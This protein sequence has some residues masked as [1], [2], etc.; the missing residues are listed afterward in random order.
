MGQILD[1][2][3]AGVRVAVIRLRSLG[4]CVLTTPALELL[5]TARPD[6]TIGVVVE[7][8]FAP[9]FEG[10]PH[11]D[12]ILA[13]ATRVVS[14]FSPRL[15]INLHGGTRSMG[16]TF[17]SGAPVRAGFAHHRYSFVYNV[18]IPTAEK[19]LGVQR[20]VHT[21]EHLG[22]AM[23]HLGVPAREIPR[24]RLYAEP[25]QDGNC[26]VLHAM[27]S[28][29]QKTW[30][31]E[32]FLAVAR[33]IEREWNIEPVFIGGRGEDLGAFHG[34]RTLVG[35]PLQRIK[36]LLSGAALFVGND[37]GPAHMAAAF[38]VPSVVI[39]GA[40]DPEIWG[41]WRTASQVLGGD[42]AIASIAVDTVVAALARVREAA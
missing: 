5:K 32:R 37:S 2:I 9:M 1:Q 41:P 13:P 31:P 30:P 10:N 34:Y 20:K 24:A 36:S 17:C 8:R 33:H 15:A 4:D 14:A 25:G 16:L 11:V 26:A 35:A 27:A 12:A 22:S 29:E 23:F 21:A 42:G 6:L 7:Q 38:Q 19:I 18:R 39:F 28:T 3:P 40:S